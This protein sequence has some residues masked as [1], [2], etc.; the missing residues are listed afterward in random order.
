MNSFCFPW[1]VSLHLSFLCCW[2]T[3]LP[4]PTCSVLCYA[5]LHVSPIS[6]HPGQF[7][8]SSS[9]KWLK[10]TSVF[11]FTIFSSSIFLHWFWQRHHPH[12]VSYLHPQCHHWLLSLLL[13]LL[14]CCNQVLM[15]LPTPYLENPFLPVCPQRIIHALIIASLNYCNVSFPGLCYIHVTPLQYIHS[16]TAKLNFLSC[17]LDQIIPFFK[18]LQKADS[19]LSSLNFLALTSKPVLLCSGLHIWFPFLSC[20]CFAPF[21]LPMML[22]WC[23]I[24]FI[25]SLLS[26]CLFSYCLLLVDKPWNSHVS[27]PQSFLFQIFL[28]I[29]LVAWESHKHKEKISATCHNFTGGGLQKMK[30]KIKQV[31][32]KYHALGLPLLLI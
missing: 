13:L 27:D 9:T 31:L 16:I 18:S 28:K 24:Y 21:G 14:P 29:S 4:F 12:C 17:G 3:N 6:H 11:F 15:R 26:L 8:P 1:I 20:S 23:F 32:S 2:L 5:T 25:I 10:L 7:A 19:C 22:P 30:V